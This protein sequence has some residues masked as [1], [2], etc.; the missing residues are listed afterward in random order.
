MIQS[1]NPKIAKT[2]KSNTSMKKKSNTICKQR[3]ADMQN[4]MFKVIVP[5]LAT[6]ASCRTEV[7]KNLHQAFLILL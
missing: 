2:F 6:F 1:F 3:L 5:L 4:T 7:D